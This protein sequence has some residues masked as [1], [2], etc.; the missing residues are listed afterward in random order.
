[1]KKINRIGA[2]ALFLLTVW[3]AGEYYASVTSS[4]NPNVPAQNSPLSSSVLRGNAMAAYNDH[5]SR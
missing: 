4:V 1:M 5:Q 3:L 2:A